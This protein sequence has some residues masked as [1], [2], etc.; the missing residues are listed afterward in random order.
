MGA[1]VPISVDDPQNDDEIIRR[2]FME[3]LCRRDNET[4][5]DRNINAG[6]DHNVFSV[7]EI[8]EKVLKGFEL[9]RV[10]LFLRGFEMIDD[11]LIELVDKDRSE[12][13]RL[14]DA[15]RAH[16]EEFA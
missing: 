8:W 3:E 1:D 10:V 14:T 5:R 13:V 11:P 6:S 16:C 12:Q 9:K 4:N 15:G 2:N 7:R